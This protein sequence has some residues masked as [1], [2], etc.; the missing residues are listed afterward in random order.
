[1]FPSFLK[2]A[3]PAGRI[4]HLGFSETPAD[5]VP[6][7]I[8]KKELSIFGSRLN[9]GMFPLVIEWF[10]RGLDPEKLVSHSFPFTK[11]RDA[12]TLIKEKPFETCKILLT[13]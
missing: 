12:F 11:A 4:A 5:I 8:T 10:K 2:L 9:C 1:M 3:S 6:L 7:E 13:F